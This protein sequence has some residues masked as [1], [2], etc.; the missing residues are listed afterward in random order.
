MDSQPVACEDKSMK[1]VMS[2]PERTDQDKESS[3]EKRT[4]TLCGETH[5]D[6]AFCL[7]SR[8]SQWQ[9]KWAEIVLDFVSCLKE[10]E[11]H[12]AVT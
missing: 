12:I 6:I 10:D 9:R 11:T 7:F 3:N 8:G 1:T 4:V 2:S 5:V